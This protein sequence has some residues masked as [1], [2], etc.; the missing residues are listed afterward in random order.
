MINLT[1][2]DSA[3]IQD[4]KGD[5]FLIEFDYLIIAT[6]FSYTSPVKDEGAITPEQRT[7]RILASNKLLSDAR[8]ILIVGGGVVG[9]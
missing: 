1:L 3:L 2:E 7:N 6:G 5:T 9:C 8:S 4:K